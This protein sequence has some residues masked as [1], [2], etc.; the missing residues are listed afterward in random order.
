[1]HYNATVL[2]S[3]QSGPFL[4]REDMLWELDR[5]LSGLG[6]QHLHVLVT[7]LRQVGKSALAKQ[8][9]RTKHSAA[10][11][12]VLVE[13][14][15]V[16]GPETFFR[17]VYEGL[18]DALAGTEH[19]GTQM[20]AVL[21][22]LPR[23]GSAVLNDLAGLYVQCWDGTA[24]ANAAIQSA[25]RLPER[26]GRERRGPVVAVLDEVQELLY[27]V[28]RTSGQRSSRGADAVAWGARG[29][30]QHAAFGLWVFTT[31]VRTAERR[32]FRGPKAPFHMQVHEIRVNPLGHAETFDLARA[33]A[34]PNAP[35]TSDALEEL[36]RLSGGL[37]GILIHLL[38][39]CPPHANKDALRDVVTT[40]FRTGAIA[41]LYEEITADAAREGRHGSKMLLS[42]MH[43]LARGEQSPAAIARR[44]VVTPAAASNLLS[45]LDQLAL[46]ERVGRAKRR[47]TYP[48]MREW[49][50]SQPVPPVAAR[51]D[52][53]VLRTQLGFGAEARVREALA[54]LTR[55]LVLRDDAEGEIL[56]GSAEEITLG[57]YREV[58]QRR[59]E[60]E[61]DV[62][63]I[64]DDHTLIAGCRYRVELCSASDIRAHDE[65]QV[66]Q[67]RAEHPHIRPAYMAAAGF[68][69]GAIAEAKSRGITLIGL[70]GMNTLMAAVGHNPLPPPDR[71]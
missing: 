14:A 38:R 64:A 34:D 16:L 70:K 25:W 66:T 1:M 31:S 24:D 9:L 44:L 4:H 33:L 58:R 10:V 32:F 21:G 17:A 57:P 15:N 43:A 49:L 37:P 6:R 26:I 42:A 35:P 68:T 51:V 39:A 40:S 45:T 2:Y 69:Q 5:T 30:V 23:A 7:G 62:I 27:Q 52:D 20:N 12:G 48:L 11:P 59:L 65:Q 50:Q 46:T 71:I 54:A 56:F 18:V 3:E 60:P 28:A 41:A 13:G 29:N 61:T 67:A 47:F 22:A 55:P 53:Q 63:A 36:A 19:A 8:F